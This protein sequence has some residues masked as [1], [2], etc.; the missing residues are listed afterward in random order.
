MRFGA[1]RRLEPGEYTALA[2]MWHAAWHDGHGAIVPPE[3]VAV[4]TLSDFRARVPL[5]ADLCRVIGP[6]GRPLGVCAVR[7]N[8]IYQLF[9][10]QTAKGTGVAAQLLTEGEGRIAQACH[11]D[12]FLDC[13]PDNTRALRFYRRNGWCEDGLARVDLDT[14]KGAFAIDTMILRKPLTF[15]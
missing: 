7:T 10:A 14:S 3:L 1:V 2:E 8:E 6:I 15:G 9:V 13:H 11:A 4:R 12:G 5:I